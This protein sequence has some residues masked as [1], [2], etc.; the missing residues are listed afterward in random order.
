MSLNSAEAASA[1]AVSFGVANSELYYDAFQGAYL[2][3]ASVICASVGDPDRG[4]PSI[5]EWL[6]RVPSP[7]EHAA[8]EFVRKH[9]LSLH[10]LLSPKEK[11]EN[12]ENPLQAPA[13]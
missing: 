10:S 2:A 12:E 13:K 5:A 3:G 11:E 8:Y 6:D 4:I 7:V 9:N 1:E